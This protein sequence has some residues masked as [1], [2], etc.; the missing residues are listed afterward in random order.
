[1]SM[2]FNQD[3]LSDMFWQIP[4]K[5]SE[6]FLTATIIT[7]VDDSTVNWKLLSKK[8][9]IGRQKFCIT[10][11]FLAFDFSNLFDYSERTLL[12]WQNLKAEIYPRRFKPLEFSNQ[13]SLP[14]VVRE[15]KI[16]LWTYFSKRFEMKLFIKRTFMLFGS[17]SQHGFLKNEVQRDDK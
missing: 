17:K 13:V 11:I 8:K 5:N 10:P 4:Y 7:L 12:P 6:N 3:G 2:P 16:A 15:V 1:M 9:K 14:S